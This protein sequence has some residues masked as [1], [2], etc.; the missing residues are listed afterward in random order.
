VIRHV[1]LT[2][3]YSRDQIKKIEMVMPSGTCIHG[4][5]GRPE[6]K[7]LLGRPTHRWDV[8][9]E[10]EIGWVHGLDKWLV[11]LNA[12]IFFNYFVTPSLRRL[13]SYFVLA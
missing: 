4:L 9:I 8:N 3:C 5:V 13:T 2:K 10:I 11:F 6:G 1:T 12:V 7:K